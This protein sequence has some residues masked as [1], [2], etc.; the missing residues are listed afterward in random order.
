[1][2]MARSIILVRKRTSL[3]P[4]QVVIAL[5]DFQPAFA[6]HGIR[7]PGGTRFRFS[8]A[9]QKLLAAAFFGI[10]AVHDADADVAAP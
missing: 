8:C 3:L 1:L 5:R 4:R 7:G 2:L 9:G 6:K 10:V